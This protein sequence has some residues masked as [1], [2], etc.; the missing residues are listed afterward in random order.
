MQRPLLVDD[1]AWSARLVDRI[2]RSRGFVPLCCSTVSDAL[3]Q[4]EALPP[5]FLVTSP[6]VGEESVY[7]LVQRLHRQSPPPKILVLSELPLLDARVQALQPDG[8]L[9]KPFRLVELDRAIERL[10]AL[11]ALAAEPTRPLS[12]LPAAGIHGSLAQLGLPSLMT[13]L[14]ME[15]K[16]GL[17]LLWRGAHSARVFFQNGRIVSARL[18]GPQPQVGLP[19]LFGLLGWTEGQFDFTAHV[20]PPAVETDLSITHL[21]LENARRKDERL[22][23][24]AEA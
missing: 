20:T 10:L 12:P 16:T 21:L 22:H 15:R 4:A 2:L 9:H 7:P 6:V 8:Y 1:D 23:G 19:S 11:P 14:E 13:L 24:P 3:Q 5:H 17:L 18:L